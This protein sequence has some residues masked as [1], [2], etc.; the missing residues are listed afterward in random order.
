MQRRHQRANPRQ[1]A[2]QHKPSRWAAMKTSTY[3]PLFD[4]N[5]STSATA[6]AALE[7][8]RMPRRTRVNL[9]GE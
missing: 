7:F 4:A 6:N 1:I 8:G 9:P 2:S 5:R 3:P